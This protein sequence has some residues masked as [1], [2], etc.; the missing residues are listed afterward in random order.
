MKMSSQARYEL[1]KQALSEGKK[2][3]E[4][5]REQGVTPAL[6]SQVMKKHA[7]NLIDAF[8]GDAP[9]PPIDGVQ[10]ATAAEGV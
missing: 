2:Q 5:A 8:N 9:F 7:P 1:I 4:I 10:E 3:S 6:I